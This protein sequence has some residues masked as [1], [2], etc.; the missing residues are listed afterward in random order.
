M[1]DSIFLDGNS[2][3]LRKLSLDDVT[4]RYERWLNDRAVTEYLEVG[5]FPNTISDIQSFVADTNKNSNM[6]FLGIF[7]KE[8]DEHVG[9]IKLGPI[10]WVH[11]RAELGIMV[12]EE[13]ARGVGVGKESIDL[14]LRHAFSR[15]N[16][17]RVSLG[18][19]ADH[20]GAIRCYEKVGFVREGLYRE[21][22]FKDGEML[23]TVRMAILASD[24]P[25]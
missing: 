1:S 21:S 2:V 18:V 24:Y 11:R 7:L 12:G 25:I 5:S 20:I 6:L 22:F 16:L 9:N 19:I 23:D 15:L 8:N 17:H 10:D 13:S 4:V 3:F 14:V